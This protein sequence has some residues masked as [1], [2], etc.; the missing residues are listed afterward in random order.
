MSR[1]EE[2]IQEL[3]PNGV[4]Y[5]H[6]KEVVS[7][8]R[9]TSI[10]KKDMKEGTI[11]VISGGRTPAYFCDKSNRDEDII[12]VAGSGAGAGFVQY[13]NCPIF[14]CDCFTVK[15]NESLS[16]K[17]V[18]YY[19]S[20]IQEKIYSTKKGSGVPHVYISDIESFKIPVPPIEVQC[21]IVRILDN[22]TELTAKL[23]AELTAELTAI[24]QQYKYYRDSLFDFDTDEEVVKV[25]DVILS[26]STG[27]N[28]R[29]NF[30]LN[31]E[32]ADCLYVTGKEI[33]NNRIN[34]SIRTD[35]I[36]KSAVNLI[37][38]RAKLQDNVLLF[39]STGCSTVGRMAIIEHYDGTWNV[40]E[41]MYCIQ[42][43]ENTNLKYLMYFLYS[44]IAKNQ[45]EPLISKGTVPHLKVSDL[46]NLNIPLPSL[47]DQHRIVDILDKFDAY[48]NDL[49]QGL[50]A[51]IELRKQQYEYYR[52][53]LLS[54][55]ELK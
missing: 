21:E 13:W 10:T 51:E 1:L 9:G 39:A 32:G 16:T 26:L 27:L 31:E 19:L 35:K 36:I 37:N 22:F 52:D 30:K 20:N 28:P 46:L 14:A 55:K 17:F 12:S 34:I 42:T 43:K 49:T 47:E 45:Y 54:F 2:L 24:K 41:T 7:M 23:T 15:G 40:S 50:S 3:C 53:K 33:Y 8:Q 5:K 29:K 11:P 25:R 38:R 4:E 44:S 48:C 6:L 18:Y